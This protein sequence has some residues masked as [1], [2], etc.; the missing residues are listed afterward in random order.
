V[1][2][3]DEDSSG[4]GGMR[5]KHAE[6]VEPMDSSHPPS[7]SARVNFALGPDRG[8][9]AVGDPEHDTDWFRYSVPGSA[10]R[11]GKAKART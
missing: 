4:Y 10:Q 11:S 5:S 9:G 6:A 2:V 1:T 8:D 3:R 7:P